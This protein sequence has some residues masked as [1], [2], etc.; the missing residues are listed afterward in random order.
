MRFTCDARDLCDAVSIAA[1]VVPSRSSKP[2]LMNLALVSR[3]GSLEVLATDLEVGL[4]FNLTRVDVEAEGAMLVNAA[5]MA[6][7]L[8]E[9]GDQRVSITANDNSGCHIE[10]ESP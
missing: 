5:R 2:V 7:I 9:L 8:K 1:T 4:R 10:A 6:Q 3:E